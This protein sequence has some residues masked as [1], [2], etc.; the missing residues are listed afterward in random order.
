MPVKGSFLNLAII[1]VIRN[2]L[3]FSWELHKKT[4]K[5]EN[6]RGLD[7]PLFLV[8][9]LSWLVL[10]TYVKAIL[11]GGFPPQ[12]WSL[13]LKMMIRVNPT[14]FVFSV[15]EWLWELSFVKG[16]QKVR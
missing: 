11:D 13:G 5:Q 10:I 8:A 1:G 12:Q 3:G 16:R 15:D 7:T 9:K 2:D 6:K 14:F 4:S